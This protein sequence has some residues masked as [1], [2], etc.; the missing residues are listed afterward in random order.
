MLPTDLTRVDTDELIMHLRGA[1]R[2]AA[3]YDDPT[4]YRIL[5]EL[6]WR[7]TKKFI[8][9]DKSDAVLSQDHAACEVGEFEQTH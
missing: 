6:E 2:D 3:N 5:K 9:V 8:K 4:F 7:C 1:L